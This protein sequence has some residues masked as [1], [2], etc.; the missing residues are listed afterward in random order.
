MQKLVQ[1]AEEG[2]KNAI[3]AAQAGFGVSASQQLG[4]IFAQNQYSKRVQALTDPGAYATER[5]EA[6]KKL[7]KAV[8]ETYSAALQKYVDT[9]M[10][11]D[12]AQHFAMQAAANERQIQQ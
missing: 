11:T 1:D 3:G 10:A 9:G 12:V 5:K 4:I 7:V 8:D 2:I 6:Y